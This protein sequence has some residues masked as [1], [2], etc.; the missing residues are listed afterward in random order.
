VTDLL[1]STARRL[2]PLAAAAQRDGRL[3]SLVVGVVRDGGLAWSCGLGSVEGREPGTDVQYRLG[4]ITKSLVAVAVMRLRDEGLLGLDDPFERHVPGTPYGERTVGQLLAHGAG[5]R[6]EAPGP[7][8]ERTPGPAWP[9]LAGQLRP[10]DVPHGAGRRFHYSN[11]GFGSL[12]ELLGR[13]RGRPWLQVVTDEVLRP[14]GM[15]RTTARPQA[16]AARGWAV[17]PHADLLLPEPEEDAGALGPAGQ[18][19]STLA[20]LGRF[21]A[22]LLGDAGDVLAA[23]TLSEM[24]LAAGVD[25]TGEQWSAYALGLQVLQVGGRTLVGHGGSMPGFLAGV[26]VDP[27]ED[28]GVVLMCNATTGLGSGIVGE[29]LDVVRSAEPRVVAP[30]TP[31]T[32][33]DPAVLPLLGTWWWG[34]SGYALRLGADGLLGLRGLGLPG[35]A[36][37]FRPNG[38]GSWTGLDGY[39]AGEALRPVGDPPVALDLGSFVFT[40]TAYDT[41]APVPG[42]VDDGGWRPGPA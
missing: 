17:H 25:T 15:H 30:W 7:W 3:P 33:V 35:R 26:T 38:D 14:L 39:H 24:Q 40:R 23:D 12:G 1:P 22:F 21:G 37:R 8:W 19:W 2:L 20:D 11:L 9:E 18:L 36:S 28:A 41:A 5:L 27:A 13:L 31:A 29:V 10:S 32:S 34:T 16:P 4:S 42:G 6:A